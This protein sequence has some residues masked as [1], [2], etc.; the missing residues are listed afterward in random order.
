MEK[1]GVVDDMFVL[2]SLKYSKRFGFYIL[3]PGVGYRNSEKKFREKIGNR[4]AELNIIDNAFDDTSISV[5]FL[6][7]DKEKTTDEVY[8]E[9]VD[10]KNGNSILAS[11]T[12]RLES[13]KWNPITV[14]SEKEVINIS[15][16]NIK[17]SANLV[18]IVRNNLEIEIF[19]NTE[20]GEELDVLENIRKIKNICIEY[21]NILKGGKWKKMQKK[22][23]Q[24][25]SVKQLNLFSPITEV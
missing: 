3:F 18:E 1:S 10:M 8:R 21:E 7:I 6:V 25:L 5:L 12:T 4:L 15:E 13:D 14:E 24:N 20:L 17:L 22:S 16:I 11:D 9:K 2:M 19:L 23:F